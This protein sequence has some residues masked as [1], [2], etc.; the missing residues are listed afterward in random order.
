MTLWLAWTGNARQT[1]CPVFALSGAWTVPR[2]PAGV[3]HAKAAE[4]SDIAY[5]WMLDSLPHVATYPGAPLSNR[6]DLQLHRH[7]HA[8]WDATGIARVFI[9]TFVVV[10]GILLLTLV[11]S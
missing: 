11:L 5:D 1:T 7:V 10:S 2:L 4:I 8:E 9:I 6:P 3:Q